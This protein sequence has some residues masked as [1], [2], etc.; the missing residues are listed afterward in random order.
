MKTTVRMTKST[1]RLTIVRVASIIFLLAFCSALVAQVAPAPAVTSPEVHENGK[2]SFRVL[3]PRATTVKL[4]G[5]DIP[6]AGGPRS[7]VLSKDEKGVW[8]VTIDTLTPGAYRYYFDIDGVRVLDP[9]NTRTSQ[10]NSNLWSLV[11]VPGNDLFDTKNV[12]HGAVSEVLYY[13]KSLGRERRMH[14]YTPPGYESGK[15]EYPVFYLLHGAFDNDDAWSTVGRAGIIIDNLIDAGKAVPMVVVMPDGH[16]GPFDFSDPS[17]FPRHM[18]EFVEDFRGSIR[19][20]IEK[21]YR[22]KP[23]AENRAIAGLSMG[24]AHTLEIF[25]RDLPD[26]A[27]YGVFS[28]GVLEMRPQ[29]A[30]AEGPAWQER[31]ARVLSDEKL[32]KNLR[33]IWFA[34][35]KEDFLLEVNDKT[36]ALLKESGFNVEEKKTEGGHTWVNWREY[37]AKFVPMLF[38]VSK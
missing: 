3:A 21:N 10:A 18:R 11:I 16:T 29:N 33:L 35:G 24:G 30:P 36:V 22:L 28:S 20:Y 7:P 15:G 23:G 19:P 4:E 13:S 9:V 26:F 38:K 25:A 31:H 14:V 12:P 17:I 34:I 27:Y 37:L 2:I 5:T 8:S 6:D 1:P 32:R